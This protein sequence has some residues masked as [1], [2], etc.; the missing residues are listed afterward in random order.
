MERPPQRAR[1]HVERADISRERLTGCAWYTAHHND[2]TDNQRR[3]SPA[4]ALDWTVVTFG[5]IDLTSVAEICVT[6]AGLGV[7][8][9]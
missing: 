1:A 8:R 3:S 9:Q 5:E 2:I 7:E 4:E 6:F